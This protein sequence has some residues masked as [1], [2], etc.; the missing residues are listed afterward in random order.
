M[1]IGVMPYSEIDYPKVFDDWATP[2]TLG[3]EEK[4][5]VGFSEK[6]GGTEAH[7]GEFASF[8]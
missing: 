4:K 3:T 1:L 7:F 2:E 5:G 8:K 6:S